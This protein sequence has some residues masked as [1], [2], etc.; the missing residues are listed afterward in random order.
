MDVLSYR[1]SEIVENNPRAWISCVIHLEGTIVLVGD[2]RN[3]AVGE[4]EVVA[5]LLI[6]S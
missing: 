2:M 6:N 1:A 3:R 4:L 5:T